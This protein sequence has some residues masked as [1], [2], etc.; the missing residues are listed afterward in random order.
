MRQNHKLFL[1]GLP[2]SG[3]S[4]VVTK[5][6]GLMEPTGM[7][8]LIDARL[9]E[10]DG[11]DFSLDK[12]E[13]ACLVWDVREHFSAYPEDWLKAFF[14]QADRLVLTNWTQLD[15]MA[16]NRF[17]RQLKDYY[18]S[19]V[20]YADTLAPEKAAALFAPLKQAF[21]CFSDAGANLHHITLPMGCVVLDHLL[22]VLDMV[23]QN[24]QRPIW[25][26]AALLDTL[27]Y[28]NPVVLDMT[29]S[30]LRTFG[31]PLDRPVNNKLM[32]GQLNVWLDA[33]FDH[34]QLQEWL[35]A[36]LAPG[37]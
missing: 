16:Q 23:Q 4:S 32:P 15:L 14:A 37:A 17:K 26:A 31:W 18:G 21:P 10:A 2:G 19:A 1:I 34:A 35:D 20:F 7:A 27:E 24:Y 28:A 3:K 22:F 25:R 30:Q 6:K 5:L 29:H 11:F 33:S 36:S 13:Q 12:D 9:R 8:Q